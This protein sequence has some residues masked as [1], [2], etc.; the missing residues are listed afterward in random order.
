MQWL[1][2]D[3]EDALV[4]QSAAE[5]HLSRMPRRR[6]LNL[7]SIF[8]AARQGK[9]FLMNR[10]AGGKGCGFAVSNKSDPCTVGVDLAANTVSLDDF[11]GG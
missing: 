2:L 4:P 6:P 7:I 11:S 3:E 10:L 5:Q 9:S 1:R 8:G